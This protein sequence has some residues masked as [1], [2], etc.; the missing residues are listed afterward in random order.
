MKVLNLMGMNSTKFGGMEKFNI[1]LIRQGL[2]ISIVYNS[3]PLSDDYIRL[4]LMYEVPLYICDC[5]KF[6]SIFYLL[7]III[8]ESPDIIHYHFSGA[9]YHL[10]SIF[11]Y[12]FKPKVKQVHTIHC[13]PTKIRGIRGFLANLFYKCQDK[14]IAV[15]AGVYHGFNK[16]FGSE[17]NIVVSYLGVQREPITKDN[18]R[19]DLNINHNTLVITSIGWDINI[20][21]YDVLLK[22]VARLKELNLEQDFLVVIIG[23]PV[24]EERTLRILMDQYELNDICISVGIREDIDDFLN[25]TDIYIQ[26]SRSEAISL[27]IM[28][29]LQYGIPIIGS[30]VG[31]IPEVC[32]NNYNGLLFESQNSEELYNKL[33]QLILSADLRNRYGMHSYE[34]SKQYLRPDRARSLKEIYNSL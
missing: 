3:K 32:V 1:E 33:E 18:L 12:F 13:E 7:K 2:D 19:D 14:I 22:A 11:I 31:G 23:L 16:L 17:Y 20:K 9:I 26:P 8:R 15:S 28:E 21:G 24:E 4:M 6:S 10:L 25:I 34:L 29:A 5:T 30:N 27:S